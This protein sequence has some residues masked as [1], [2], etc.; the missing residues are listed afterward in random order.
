LL[1]E[2]SLVRIQPGEPFTFNGLA[3]FGALA[4]RPFSCPD[5]L[6]ENGCDRLMPV[7]FKDVVV[8]QFSKEKRLELDL[9]KDLRPQRSS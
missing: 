2:W 8:S 1:I 4:W 7:R 3:D 6:R 9:L 5:H